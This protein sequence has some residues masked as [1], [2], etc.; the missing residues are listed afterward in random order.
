MDIILAHRQLDFDALAS[1]VAVQKLYPNSSMVM[2]GKATAYVQDFLALAKDQLPLK[3]GQDL[4]W[5]Q[6]ERVVLVDT[7]DLYRAGES[8]KKAASLPGVE[9]VIYDHHPYEGP[10]KPGMHIEP[11]GACTTLLVEKIA[12]I[13]LQLSSFEATLLALGIYDDTGSLLFENTTVRDARAVAFLLEQGAQLGV[14][15]E[16]LSRPLSEEQMGLLQ[17][18]LDNGQVEM[19]KGLPVY[20]SHAESLEYVGGLALLAHRVGELEGPET[21]FLTV[22]MENRVYLVGRS[23]GK[24]LPVH[25]IMRVFGG[26]GHER[27]AS[28]TIKGGIPQEVLEKLQVEISNRVQQPFL[29]QDIMSYPVKTVAPNAKLSDVEQ[30][31]LRYGH[32]GVPVVEDRHLI[33]IISRRDVD[34][35]LKHGLQHA[36]VKAFMATNVITVAAGLPWD[37][38][39]R[40]MVQYDIGRLPVV[41][42]GKLIGIVSR[43]DVL[44]LI[45]GRAVPTESALARERSLAGRQ[46]I[47]ELL[48]RLPEPVRNLL[49][50]TSQAA[51]ERRYSVYAVGG[52]VR[53]L[54]LF[55]PTQ[56]LDLVV[57]GNGPQFAEALAKYLGRGELTRHPQFGTASLNFSDGTHLDVA[58][59]RWEYYEFPGA[60]PE[61]EESSLRDDLFRRDFTINAMAIRLNPERYG[62]LVDYYG[63]IRDLQQG[64]IRLL[65]NLSFI[66]DPTRI[67]RAVRFAERYRFRLAKE[68]LD[69]L[70]TALENGVILKLSRERFSEELL[71][72]YQEEHYLAMGLTLVKYGVLKEWFGEEYPWNY[73]GDEGEPR[74]RALLER[75]LFSLKRFNVQQAESVLDRLRLPRSLNENTRQYF[76]LRR[77]LERGSLELLGID[78]LL[79]KVPHPLINLLAGEKLLAEYLRPYLEAVKNIHMTVDGKTLQ[80]A[81]VQRGLRIGQILGEIRKAWLLGKICTQEEEETLMWQLIDSGENGKG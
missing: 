81:G 48:G 7:H 52:F 54:L 17:Q 23:R 34:K 25:E 2:E 12:G 46:D 77:E 66:D 18:L 75:W 36:P 14:V 31:L 35:A 22:K 68:T 78:R 41:E 62:E 59:T 60:L 61:V 71:L 70:K 8:G 73:R 67:L 37:T 42:E 4:D 40:L 38:A 63:G 55:A 44:R 80:K 26:S 10:L 6:V 79:K 53:D 9:I 56:D 51:A 30:L 50:M 20:L 33:G 47:Q 58:S 19:F 13:G 39:Q 76:E 74:D 29:V 11:L 45:H 65:H 3:A 32:T 24:G 16:N 27:A 69:A 49:E 43:S 57:E 21:W 15:A 1:M 72:M 64:E 5:E 28:A